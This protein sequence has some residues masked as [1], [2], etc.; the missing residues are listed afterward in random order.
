M[1]V[2]N[3]KA[4]LSPLKEALMGVKR[5][6]DNAAQMI[7]EQAKQQAEEINAN[8]ELVVRKMQQDHQETMSLFSDMLGNERAEDEHLQD[9]KQGGQ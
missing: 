4:S 6:A 3:S 1:P 9:D 8:G 5:A 2:V 7:V